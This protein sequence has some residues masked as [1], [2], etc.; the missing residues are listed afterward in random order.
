MNS[1]SIISNPS[2]QKN[3]EETEEEDGPED[4]GIKTSDDGNKGQLI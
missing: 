1:N 3:A 4:S 2:F